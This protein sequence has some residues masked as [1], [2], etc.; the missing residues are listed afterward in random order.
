MEYELGSALAAFGIVHL[1]H[2][3]NDNAD[4]SFS[5]QEETRSL[6][7]CQLAVLAHSYRP[8]RVTLTVKSLVDWLHLAVLMVRYLSFVISDMY[9]HL[10]R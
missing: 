2:T 7:V 9:L 4:F 3:P 8:Y 1:Y 6:I 10:L 5:W